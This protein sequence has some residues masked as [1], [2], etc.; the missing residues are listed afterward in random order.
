MLEL[1]DRSAGAHPYLVTPE[2]TARAETP[3]EPAHCWPS[4]RVWSC[5]RS[6][7]AL[8][9]RPAGVG[10]LR[11][12]AELREQLE[13]ARLHDEDAGL[14]DRLIDALVAWGDPDTVADRVQAHRDAGADHV[15][16]QVI[17]SRGA[18]PARRLAPARPCRRLRRSS[19]AAY[20]RAQSMSRAR[21]CRGSRRAERRAPR[22]WSPGRRERPSPMRA[23]PC[24]VRGRTGRAS[25]WP[26]VRRRSPR[27]GRAHVEHGVAAVVQQQ[28]RDVEP[29]APWSTATA[30][31]TWRCRRPGARSRVAL[32]MPPRR[33]RR[34]GPDRWRRR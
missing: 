32:G 16:V 12:A 29:L 6:P 8:G 14:S 9:R 27:P 13:A 23:R 30:G 15:C 5:R 10:D 20:G 2:H 26:A 21:A 4:N 31:C 3:W 1:A 19:G 22:R 33:W 18:C 28:H 11:H 24:R 7:T 34:A 25:P 17:A